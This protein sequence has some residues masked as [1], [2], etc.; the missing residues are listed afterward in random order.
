MKDLSSIDPQ[1]AWSA[2]E[3]TA[4]RPWSIPLAAH[5]YRRAAFGANWDELHH[6]MK[7]GP[8]ATIAKLFEAPPPSDPFEQMSRTLAQRTVAAGD[9]RRLA[10][11][12]LYRMLHAPAPLIE[13][14]TLLW[15]GHFATSA[16]KV[17]KARLMLD[18]NELLRKHA[19]DS[20]V[21]MVRGVARD[22]AM[23][24]YLDAAT[25]RR[26]RP[27]ENFARE[28]MELFCLGVGHYT[29]QDIRE[30]ARAF[31][32]WEV[33]ADSFW[34][35][36]IQHDTGTKAILGL[37]GNFGGDEAVDVVVAHPASSRFIARKL[38]RYFAF[39]EPD[40]A[41]A[42]VEPIAGELRNGKFQIAPAVKRILASNLFFSEHSIGRKIRS[43]LD[44]GIGLL[45]SLDMTTNLLKLG[46]GAS[47]LGQ[48]LFR[49]PNVKGWDGGR[50]W[51]NSST[52]LGRANFV[53]QLLDAGE[54]KPKSGGDLASLPERAGC[55]EPAQ[56]VDWLSQLLLAQPLPPAART[57]LVRL[58]DQPSST[59][60]RSAMVDAIHA[61]AATPEFQLA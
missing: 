33:R 37:S 9:V 40:P 35:N 28:L 57:E 43:P 18:Q 27:N 42:L 39:D 25:N 61:L 36:E 21:E 2:Y 41:D 22:P 44:V 46:D 23:L 20:F 6:A 53:R 45:R 34:F 58:L 11:W 14:L 12:W 15:H 31:T 8:A 1:W 60:D 3:P 13:K 49:P 7:V 5:L 48:A 30:L 47:E 16:A 59:I 32:G 56:V 10:G 29:E 38:I 54:T 17:D 55:H 4:R 52:L 26:I 19:A 51:I 24:L 50:A